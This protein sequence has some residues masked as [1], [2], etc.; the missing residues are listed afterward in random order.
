MGKEEKLRDA[1]INNIIRYL[2]EENFPRVIKC[3]NMLTEEEIWYRPNK[4]SNS[5]GNLVLHLVGN[6]NQWVLGS[7]GRRHNERNRQEEFDADRTKN[8][9]E[10]LEMLDSLRQDLYNCIKSIDTDD[11]LLSRPVQIYEENGTTILIH[12]T[13]HFSY[14]TGQIAYLTKWLKDQQTHFYETLEN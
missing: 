6:L 12:V 7:M 13:E 10:L 5:I 14:H 2:L 3:I 1:F 9:A 8:K 4:N 11:L